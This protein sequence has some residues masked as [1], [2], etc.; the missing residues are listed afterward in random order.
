VD[1]LESWEA[2]SMKPEFWSIPRTALFGAALG[3]AFGMVRVGG[4]LSAYALGG[5]TVDVM[6]GAIIGAVI[7][8]SLPTNRSPP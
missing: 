6:I 3:A 8:R 7:A 1:V 4:D 2:N 5:V